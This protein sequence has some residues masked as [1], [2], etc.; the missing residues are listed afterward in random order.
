[1]PKVSIPITIDVSEETAEAVGKG[2]TA[3]KA[4][5][6]V[7]RAARDSGVAE[8]FAEALAAAKKAARRRK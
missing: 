8:Q 6:G 3:L 7:M 2:A 4:F 5:V 1:M